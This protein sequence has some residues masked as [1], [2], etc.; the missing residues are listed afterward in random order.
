MEKAQIIEALGQIEL[1]RDICAGIVALALGAEVILG[2]RYAAKNRQLLAIQKQEEQ[3]LN[4]QI[5]GLRASNLG[6]QKELGKTSTDVAKL[7]PG[8]QPIKSIMAKVFLDISGEGWNSV[9][10]EFSKG[11]EGVKTIFCLN[12]VKD[13]NESMLRIPCSELNVKTN[14]GPNRRV[15]SIEFSWP[16]SDGRVAYM[17]FDAFPG[18]K[19][20][21]MDA[22]DK[23]MVGV[24]IHVPEVLDG[25]EIKAGFCVVTF[26]GTIERKFSIPQIYKCKET[27]P[28]GAEWTVIKP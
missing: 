15:Y 5:E 7:A 27:S 14:L 23:E 8:K 16:S 6:L 21:S 2:F 1:W 24:Q 20:V 10:S 13:K 9:D 4:L 12:I 26:N 17:G 18:Q 3:Q 11:I 22:L 25:S 19:N 28:Y